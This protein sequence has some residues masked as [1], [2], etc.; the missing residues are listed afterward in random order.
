MRT[1]EF[2]SYSFYVRR[3]YL[4]AKKKYTY[5]I[6]HLHINFNKNNKDLL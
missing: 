5:I 1:D 2:F 4:L 3:S 6:S